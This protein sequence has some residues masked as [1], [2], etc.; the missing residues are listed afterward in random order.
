[1]INS[2]KLFLAT[3]S[4]VLSL[5]QTSCNSDDDANDDTN[6]QCE[7]TICTLVF[8]RINVSVTDQDEN[9][10][11]LDSFTVTNLANGNDMTISLS[12]S[13]RIA[14]RETGLY[15]LTQD[16]ILDLNEERQ[17]Q[18]KGFINDEEVVSSDYTVSTDCCHVGLDSGDLQLTF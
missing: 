6:A 3:L 10:V 1:M 5:W 13:E 14:A 18:F 17:I 16:G 11:A 9:P 15:P 7:E 8:I 4:L 12:E 2:N